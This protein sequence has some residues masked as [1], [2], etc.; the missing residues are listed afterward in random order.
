[1]AYPVGAPATPAGVTAA[2]SPGG[3]VQIDW[4]LNVEYDLSGYNLYRSETLG[5][6]MVKINAQPEPAPPYQD[7]NVNPGRYLVLLHDRGGPLR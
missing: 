1:M 6:D 5:G 7:D 4:T 2:Y 3:Y